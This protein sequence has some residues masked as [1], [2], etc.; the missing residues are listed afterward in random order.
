MCLYYESIYACGHQIYA[1]Y[2]HCEPAAMVQKPCKNQQVMMKHRLPEK[3]EECNC[4]TDP[5][6]VKIVKK[7]KKAEY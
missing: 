7:K 4:P 2:K 5:R 3:C 6:G 1:L